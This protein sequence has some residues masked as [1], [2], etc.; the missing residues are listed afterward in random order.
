MKNKKIISLIA[1]ILSGSMLISSGNLS[2]TAMDFTS[3]KNNSKKFICNHK[4][5]ISSAGLVLAV[6]VAFKI[7][8]SFRY[9]KLLDLAT[10]KNLK[11]KFQIHFINVGQGDCALI[12]YNDM[13]WLVDAGYNLGLGIIDITKYLPEIGV[14][15]LSGLVLTH[16]HPDHYWNIKYIFEKFNPKKFYFSYLDPPV[17]IIDKLN[18]L[19]YKSRVEEPIKKFKEKN[20]DNCIQV[21][22]GSTIFE[23][24]DKNFSISVIGP[25]K[26]HEDVNDNS[27]VLLIKYK[28]KRILMMGDAGVGSEKEILEYVE[29]QNIDISNVDLVKIGHHG[30]SSASS[31]EFVKHTNPDAIVNSTGGHFFTFGLVNFHEFPWVIHRW[32]N[33][34]NRSKKQKCKVLTTEEQKNIILYYDETTKELKYA[35]KEK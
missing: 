17:N 24:E 29:K 9:H 25:T 35:R 30:N 27:V 4:R 23:S 7:Y 10:D 31:P 15:E 3:F 26:K 14:E 11:S 21:K 19:Q 32:I 22:S 28:N 12:K 33:G 18:A 5:L 13:C 34:N 2:V 20:P 16:P 8:R 6:P 1:S